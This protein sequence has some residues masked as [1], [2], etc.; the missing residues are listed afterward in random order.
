MNNAK[1]V[2]LSGIT[3]TRQMS[4]LYDHFINDLH[5]P[6]DQVSDILR[7]QLVYAVSGFDRL[8]H[9]LI[10]KG[11]IEILLNQR[12]KTNKFLTHPFKAETLLKALEYSDPS[13]IPTSPQETTE[14]VVNKEMAEKLSFLSFQAPDKVKDGLS[15]IWTETQKMAVLAD[16]IGIAGATTNDRQKNLEQKLAL[17]VDRRNQIAHEGDIDPSTN[18]KRD[19]TKAQA[20]DAINFVSQLGVSIHKFV[21]Q[22][23]CYVSPTATP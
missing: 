14:F 10:R 8:I 12:V 4:A 18:L 15:F 19:I 5:I 9:E 17:I 7:F 22:P 13:Y 16:D 2:F 11:V 20:E 23:T 21:T 3:K 6:H 1:N